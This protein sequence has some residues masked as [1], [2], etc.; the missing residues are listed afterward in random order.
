MEIR[1]A[2]IDVGPYGRCSASIL[3]VTT[4]TLAQKKVAALL[5]SEFII[6]GIGAFAMDVFSRNGEV[7]HTARYRRLNP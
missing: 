7:A 2:W 4:G 1:D 5:L 3:P 6:A